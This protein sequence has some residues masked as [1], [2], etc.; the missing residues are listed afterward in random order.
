MLAAFSESVFLFDAYERQ[1]VFISEQLVT[2]LGYPAGTAK[3]GHAPTSEYLHP[4]DKEP[5]RTLSV[6]VL[7]G[8]LQV[9][10]ASIRIRHANGSYR[11]FSLRQVVFDPSNGPKPRYLFGVLVDIHLR[12]EAELQIRR[13]NEAIQHYAF[14]ASHIVRAPLANILGLINLLQSL[15]N[16]DG[17]ERNTLLSLLQDCAVSL[18][19]IVTDLIHNISTSRH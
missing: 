4:D 15:T 2:A 1:I 9:A 7:K 19:Q 16:A 17:D 10:A 3:A 14:T 5:V 6:K 8:E 11:W 18:D 13:Q 12:K